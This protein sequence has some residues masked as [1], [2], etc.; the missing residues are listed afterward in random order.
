MKNILFLLVFLVSVSSC[1][2]AEAAAEDMTV[3]EM[4]LPLKQKS[5]ET[6]LFMINQKR[7]K[8]K[9]KKILNKKSSKRATFD[10][11]LTI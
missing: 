7:Q 2:K 4:K 9:K 10:L 3:S 6:S 5:E 8:I 1:K 11:K